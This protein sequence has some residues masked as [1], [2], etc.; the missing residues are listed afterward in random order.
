MWTSPNEL[1]R[2]AAVVGHPA[3]AGARRHVR[4]LVPAAQQGLR[5]RLRLHAGADPQPRRQRVAVVLHASPRRCTASSSTS[6]ATFRCSTFGGRSPTSSRRPGS[7]PRPS[8]RRSGSGR[9]CSTSTCR[10]ST[11]RRRRTAPTAREALQALAELDAEIGRLVDGFAAAY[12]DATPLWLVASEY[13]DHARRSRALSQSRAA[14]RR[15]AGSAT[16]RT[17]AR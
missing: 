8:A 3:R 14:R 15:P 7:S 2:A 9:T 5:R 13:V 16:T 10:T 12:G 17:P 6:W 4:R 11:T 1:H